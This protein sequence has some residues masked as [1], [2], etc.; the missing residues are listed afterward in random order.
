MNMEKSSAKPRLVQTFPIIERQVLPIRNNSKWYK[1]L[2]ASAVALITA[3]VAVSPV[4][5]DNADPERLKVIGLTSDNR[6]VR[7]K[8]GSANR[9]RNIGVV[10]GLM[11]PDTAFVGIDFRVQDGQLY[12]VGNGGGIYTID[13]TTAVATL[14]SSLSVPLDPQATLF[15]VDF[16]PA[17]DRL[18]IVSDTGQNLRHN[19]NAGGTTTADGTLTYTAPPATPTPALGVT[20]AAYANNDLDPSTATT[21]F[22]IDSTM[23]QVVIQSPANTGI[24]VATG[25]LGG[26]VGSQVGFDIYS[27]LVDGV[28]VQNFGFAS[29]SVNGT[30]GL[31]EINLLTGQAI[32]IDNFKDDVVVDI[33]VLLNQ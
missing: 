21:L 3:F 33:A 6:L 24:L 7:C 9:T 29:L 23:D 22:D 26:D 11:S 12:G 1:L 30:Y 18:R 25:K 31:Y 14:T 32:L 16:N 13:P 27:D 10:S 19:V 20:G 28:T 2:A 8:T 15:S 5:A 4:R 17:A